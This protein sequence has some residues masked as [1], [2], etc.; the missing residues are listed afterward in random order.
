MSDDI[1]GSVVADCLVLYLLEDHCGE[2]CICNSIYATCIAL[3]ICLHW[4]N[5]WGN[6]VASNVINIVVVMLGRTEKVNFWSQQIDF[7]IPSKLMYNIAMYW[8]PK[9]LQSLLLINK[10]SK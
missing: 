2:L 9:V 1:A 5:E 6:L 8:T 10:L 4:G 3:E 7:F